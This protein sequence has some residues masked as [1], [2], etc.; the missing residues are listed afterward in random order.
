MGY[1]F[2][3]EYP[4]FNPPIPPWLVI[5]SPSSTGC[6][7]GS[8]SQ[9]IQV[10][11][12]DHAPPGPVPI[13]VTG[14]TS[15]GKTCQSTGTVTVER[16]ATLAADPTAIPAGSAW[17]AIVPYAGSEITVTWEPTNCEGTLKIVE[18]IGDGGYVPPTTEGTV[19]RLEPTKW[20]YRPFF[21]SK[22][23]LCPM[24]VNVKIAA[25]PGN[26]ELDR[27]SVRMLPIHTWWTTTHQHYP[28]E[29]SH[30]PNTS[31]YEQDLSYV[32]W[33]YL[34][35]HTGTGGDF[36]STVISTSSCLSCGLQTCVYA[37]TTCIPFMGC[38]AVFGTSAL[39]GS[40]NQAASIF[41][42]ELVHTTELLFAGECPAYTWERNHGVETGIASC[43]PGYFGEVLDQLRDRDCP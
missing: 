26:P 31:D 36:S 12:L 5:S 4:T 23:E 7:G 10:T 8:Q 41:G 37:C 2:T 43:D 1:T 6:A 19:E 16:S 38:S 13:R 35:V 30:T 40:E 39:S 28:G 29:A 9:T 33:K 20:I 32:S 14:T 21:E 11:I 3:P 17:E 25:K 24:P 18:L 42:H 27:E 15:R 34:G 22:T